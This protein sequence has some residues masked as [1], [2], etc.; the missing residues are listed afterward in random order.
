MIVNNV[1]CI[2]QLFTRS[3]KTLS[4]ESRPGLPINTGL[5]SQFPGKAFLE[6][7][8]LEVIFR[9]MASLLQLDCYLCSGESKTGFDVPPFEIVLHLITSA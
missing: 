2:F 6:Y 4:I 1:S 7:I 8:Y 5:V 9:L 3:G